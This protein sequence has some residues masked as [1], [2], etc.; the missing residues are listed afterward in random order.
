MTLLRGRAMRS[1]FLA[2][3]LVILYV[4]ER[5]A[6]PDGK[7]AKVLVV[8]GIALVAAAAIVL[9]L[10]SLRASSGERRRV[11]GRIAIASGGVAL[12]LVLYGLGAREFADGS[13]IPAILAVAFPIV[14]VGALIPLVF[15][16]IAY[17]SM[18]SEASVELR[19]IDVS[20]LSG[21]SIALAICGLFALGYA[22][23]GWGKKWDLSYFKTT[24]PSRGTSRMIDRLGE[25]MEVFAYFPNVNDVRDQVMPYLRELE[26]AS[27]KVKVRGVDHAMRPSL[28][29]EHRVTKNGAIVLQ[30]G[31]KRETVQVGLDLE[32]ARS[33]LRRLD[34]DFQKA[35]LKLTRPRRTIYVTVGHKERGEEDADDPEEA[36]TEDWK[37]L[38]AEMG[39]TTRN[40][41][42]GQ[43]LGNEIPGDATA[44]AMLGPRERILPEE[45]GTL[46]SYV[47]G[48]GHLLLFVDPGEVL[49]LEPLLSSL[50][51]RVLD[52]TVC[53]ETN[54]FVRDH[55]KSDRS[56][57][58]TN[59]FSAHPTATSASRLSSRIASVFVGGGAL[60]RVEGEAPEGR[61]STFTVR[62]LTGAWRDLD[63]DF[64]FDDGPE[65]KETLNLVAAVTV[66]P[67][68]GG[69]DGE[70][71]A[72]VIADG[73]F[74]TDQVV[75]NPG[76][77]TVI[78]D[79]LR[80]LVGEAE[81]EGPAESEE[82]VRIE[83]TR[84]EDVAWFYGTIFLGPAIVLGGGLG[85]VRMTRRRRKS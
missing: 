4:G 44:V 31:D 52:G 41:G 64:E 33:K 66:R 43:G 71:R 47:E 39:I 37:Q 19:R 40:L 2:A 12:A 53:S 24:R 62:S 74:A 28:A 3:G 73:D 17:A 82:D 51:L 14:L 6:A 21:L 65:K 11:E 49:G 45:A 85:L 55:T 9:R 38:L 23:D 63:G 22:A 16:E 56:V 35:F 54:H 1:A 78:V 48:G 5:L 60:D 27:K 50:G 61:S 8:L 57:V 20:A 58:F 67:G 75:R 70:G 18:P 81:V 59:R 10:L 77:V 68:R 80:W 25:P 76:N 72:V 29:K 32:D 69:T 79:V 30:Q 34:G 84:E 15:M 83:H 42:V 36:G 13:R 26:G 7:A 46:A